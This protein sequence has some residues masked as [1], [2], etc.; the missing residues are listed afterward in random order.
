MNDEKITRETEP[1]EAPDAHSECELKLAECMNGWKRAQADYANLQKEVDRE[2]GEMGAHAVVI[3]SGEFLG[4]FDHFKRALQHAP[5]TVAQDEI[6]QWIR[7]V[8]AIRDLF[9]QTFKQFGIEEIET[10]GKSFDP[11]LMEAVAE[12]ESEESD[13]IVI[14]EIESGYRKNSHVLKP[15][16]VIISKQKNNQ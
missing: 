2:R 13:G 8:A 4:V 6:A 7:G 14:E 12:H 3:V 5:A 15:A 16:R 11:A 10:I 1:N 9:Q